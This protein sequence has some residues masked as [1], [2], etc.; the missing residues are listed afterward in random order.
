MTKN[1]PVHCVLGHRDLRSATT[2][3]DYL[4]KVGNNDW[5]TQANMKIVWRAHVHTLE[6]DEHS[7][8]C[9]CKLP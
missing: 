4:D 9:I 6:E 5:D 3:Q 1:L 8:V 2:Y 7:Q